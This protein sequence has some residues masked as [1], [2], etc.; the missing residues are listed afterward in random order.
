MSAYSALRT[1]PD[2]QNK[3]ICGFTK[4]LINHTSNS[5]VIADPGTTVRSMAPCL[6]KPGNADVSFKKMSMNTE[7]AMT[8]K[9]FQEGGPGLC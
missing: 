8:S 5:C 7:K 3:G 9:N 6:C 4:I 1:N 2:L